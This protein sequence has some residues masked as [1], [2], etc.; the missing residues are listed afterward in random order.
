METAGDESMDRLTPGMF[1]LLHFLLSV[2][3]CWVSP[4]VAGQ[5]TSAAPWPSSSFELSLFL[6][7][8]DLESYEP[9]L[10][11]YKQTSDGLTDW[12]EVT[13]KKQDCLQA[14]KFDSIQTLKEHIDNQKVLLINQSSTLYYHLCRVY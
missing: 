3:D 7:L 14:T 1:V 13:R 2:T 9:E 4:C 5:V 12:I 6:R 8:L 10:Q 11:R